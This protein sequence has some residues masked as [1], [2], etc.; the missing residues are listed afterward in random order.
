M[1]LNIK[2][3]SIYPYKPQAKFRIAYSENNLIIQYDVDEDSIRA[4]ELS[5]NG[6][7]WEDSCCEFFI[8]PKN[9]G[10]TANQK[11]E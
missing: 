11:I 3:T 8:A 9:D 2:N 10:R 4:T 7:V 6:N 5:D 1:E